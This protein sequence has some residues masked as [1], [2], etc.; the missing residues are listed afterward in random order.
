MKLITFNQTI[1]Q[2]NA[3][4]VNHL[5]DDYWV[6]P[7]VMMVEGVHSGSGGPM[8]Y[9]ANELG[10]FA[11]AW[12]GSPVV[13]NHPSNKQGDPVSA[14]SPNIS[15]QVIGRIYNTRMEGTKLKAEAWVNINQLKQ[16]SPETYQ[17]IEEGRIIEVSIGVFSEDIEKQ[18][19]FNNEEYRAIAQNLRPDH[20]ALL[21]QDEGACSWDD[22]CGVRIN[23]K[24]IENEV[25]N[26][27]TLNAKEL[28]KQGIGTQMI[29][30]E[31]GFGEIMQNI[32]QKLD[33]LDNDIRIHYLEDL[34]E[35]DFVYRVHN[36]ESGETS[37]Y[38]RNYVSKEDGSI[39][40]ST[41]PVPVR[42]DTSYIEMKSGK[43]K[44]NKYNNNKNDK[45]MTDK[46]GCPN[47]VTALIAHASTQYTEEDKEWLSAFDNV[48][49]D[50]MLPK[51]VELVVHKKT[52]TKEKVVENTATTKGAG[53]AKISKEELTETVKTIF[54]ESKDPNEFIDTFMPE[55]MKGQMKSG[56]KMYHEKRKQLI[57]GIVKNSKFEE[58]TLKAWNDDDL[59]NLHDSVVPETDYSVQGESTFSA[60]N[61]SSKDNG[62][63]DMLGLPTGD[64]Q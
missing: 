32:Q 17:L 53:P 15:N 49:L 22:G 60:N 10:K 64:K 25:K 46:K 19:T 34:F 31:I 50:K 63:G 57:D 6:L 35:D 44:R 37:Y 16:T 20:L 42:K 4:V 39:E 56:L 40:F 62:M 30:N 61:S 33:Q 48:Q 3:Q 2:S 18:G 27:K 13:I 12:N 11:E 23:H 36:R 1:E 21:P 14:N 45:C 38:K 58:E 5:G 9:T 28:L 41:D 55:G 59:Q 47:K 7:V 8:L 26:L 24:L 43:L 29:S 54:N 51:E 52:E